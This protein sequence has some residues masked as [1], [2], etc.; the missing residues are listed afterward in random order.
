MTNQQF[1]LLLS[2]RMAMT[3]R[4]L[5][6]KAGEYASDSDRLHNF[7]RAAAMLGVT[8]AQACV[9]FLAKHLVSVLDI[10]D[11]HQLP[12]QAVIDEKIGDCVNYLILLEAL[13][14]EAA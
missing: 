5:G 8:P 4:V 3:Q 7:K 14:T 13:L 11:A 10:V 1:D 12:A 2:R 9:G 6:T